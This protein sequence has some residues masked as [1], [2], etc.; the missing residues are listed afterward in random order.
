MSSSA[1]LLQPGYIVNRRQDYIW[2][3]GLPFAICFALLSGHYLPGAAIALW[4][5]IPCHF[6][7]WLR[8][9]GSPSDFSRFKERFVL[10]TMLL[11]AFTYALAF[12]ELNEGL[13][14]DL[15]FGTVGFNTNF[16]L[17]GYSLL[18][19]F[20]LLHYHYDACV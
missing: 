15:G 11:V 9:H 3:V 19:S 18:S 12:Y 4:I 8:V 14:H 10:S 17:F 2:F 6:V 16:D 5:T 7:T 20:A 1:A 13:V